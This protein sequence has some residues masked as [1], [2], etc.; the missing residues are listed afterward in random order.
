MK[1]HKPARIDYN[2]TI[3]QWNLAIDIRRWAAKK[4]NR[5]KWGFFDWFDAESELKD[6]LKSSD[7]EVI[8]YFCEHFC[9]T[10]YDSEGDMSLD[11]FQVIAGAAYYSGFVFEGM[12]RTRLGLSTEYYGKRVAIKAEHHIPSRYDPASN[13]VETKYAKKIKGT[14]AEKVCLLPRMHW[15]NKAWGTAL[16]FDFAPIIPNIPTNSYDFDK[17]HLQLKKV[18]VEL[19]RRRLDMMNYL[20]CD[21]HDFN[22]GWV[23]GVPYL[24][25]YNY[26]GYVCTKEPNF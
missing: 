22:I 3:F 5:E 10:W 15:K 17:E 7:R 14:W 8:A 12:G 21:A 26:N 9:D 11:P 6:F 24:I 2:L 4:D 20:T 25:D 16:M 1:N 13:E 23:K 18:A 19:V